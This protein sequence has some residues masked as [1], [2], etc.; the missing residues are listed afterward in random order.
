MVA[1]KSSMLVFFLTKIHLLGEH[2]HFVRYSAE[3]K[4]IDI[5]STS[6]EAASNTGTYINFG[7][8]FRTIVTNELPAA[9]KDI[10]SY[11]YNVNSLLSMHT[12]CRY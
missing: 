9:P 2:T 8:E 1:I 3:K 10:Y 7:F 11:T 12:R 4:N 5:S 6:F